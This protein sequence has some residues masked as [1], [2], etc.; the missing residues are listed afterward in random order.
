MFTY[1]QSK[2]ELRDVEGKLIGTGYSGFGEGKNNPAM[3]A[4]PGVGPIPRGAYSIGPAFDSQA[5]GRLV[6]RL[7]PDHNTPELGRNGFLIHGDSIDHPGQ[8]SHGCIVLGRQARMLI[9]DSTDKRLLVE[10]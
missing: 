1:S 8:G 3:Q 2:G 4:V 10:E 7:F 5:H 9:A 6:M